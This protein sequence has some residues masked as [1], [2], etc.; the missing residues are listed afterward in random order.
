MSGNVFTDVKE[1][2]I[3]AAVYLVLQGKARDVVRQLKPEDIGQKE[4]YDLI[5]HTLDTLVHA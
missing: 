2:K 3:G 4:V 5:M 1:E